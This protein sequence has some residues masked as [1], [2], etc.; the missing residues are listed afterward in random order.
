MIGIGHHLPTLV[1]ELCR[2]AGA[3]RGLVDFL[4][5]VGDGTGKLLHGRRGLLDRRRL[6]CGALAEIIGAGEDLA[7][8]G[9]EPG[10]CRSQLGDDVAVLVG[11]QIGVGLE[12]LEGAAILA[13]HAPGQVG[14]GDR[15]QDLGGLGDAAVDRFH[16]LVNRGGH[17]V[18]L[19]LAVGL[20]DAGGEVP[21]DGGRDD[22]THLALEVIAQRLFVGFE[23]AGRV[24]VAVEPLDLLAVL[25]EHFHRPGH[26][27]DLVAAL[28]ERDGAGDIAFGQA[29]HA[30]G[31]APKRPRNAADG[32]EAEPTHQRHQHG[33]DRR[34]LQ[35]RA[36]E[37]S[38]AALGQCLE[39]GH[40]PVD[41]CLHCT[42]ALVGRLGPGR[43]GYRL[44]GRVRSVGIKPRAHRF[45]RLL[46][47]T[48]EERPVRR[49]HIRR[50]EVQCRSM[51]LA[52]V[53]RVQREAEHRGRQ[54]PFGEIAEPDIDF[55]HAGVA[56]LHQGVEPLHE[57]REFKILHLPG[58]G[59]NEPDARGRNGL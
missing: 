55:H 42:H 7:G 34:Q 23:P 53:A 12:A 45:E 29:R 1:G 4:G 17:V 20:A 38:H 40:S 24:A 51:A 13:L 35:H 27:A 11:Q 57:A 31:D 50:Q 25:A 47:R 52:Q 56:G 15:R 28:A 6:P 59:G 54:L 33:N 36:A 2:Q 3:G 10:R 49:E 14:M 46:V 19:G 21:G 58:G 37:G 30:T 18:E 48:A 16:Q 44:C 41:R 26:V 22:P 39:T 9:L 32:K 5:I 8:S 43:R